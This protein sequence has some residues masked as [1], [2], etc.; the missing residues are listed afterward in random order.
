[1]GRWVQLAMVV[2]AVLDRTAVARA[3]VAADASPSIAALPVEPASDDAPVA[4]PEPV[5]APVF[6]TQVVGRRALPKSSPVRISDDDIRLR[7]ASTVPEALEGLPGVEI[8]TG[9]KAGDSLQIRGLDERGVLLLLDGIPIRES[10]AGHF[11]IGSLLATQ[12]GSVEV[13]RGISSVLYGANSMAGVVSLHSFEDLDGRQGNLTLTLGNP[14]RGRLRD[15][16]GQLNLVGGHGAWSFG[17]S[18]ARSQSDGFVVSN[19]FT[20]TSD[21]EAFHENGGLRDGSDVD[22]TML[23][24][25]ASYEPD[26]QWRVESIAHVFRQERGIPTFESS[27]Y[28]RHWRFTDYNTYL[29][30]L[31]VEYQPEPSARTWSL[32]SAKGAGYV[33][34]HDDTLQDYQDASYRQLTTHPLA[35]FVASSY[36]DQSAGMVLTPSWN[37]WTGNRIDLSMSAAYDQNRQR[38]IPV[39]TTAVNTEWQP[40]ETYG[41]ATFNLAAEDTQRLGRWR[42]S[43]GV[44]GSGMRL[45]AEE[46]RAH[47]YPVHERLAL[48]ADGRIFADYQWNEQTTWLIAAGR[49]TR[50]PTLK[51]LFSNSLGGNS[52]LQPE[53]AWMAEAGFD[54]RVPTYAA[55]LSARLYYNAVRALIEQ[56][57]SVYTNVSRATTAG[58]ELAASARPFSFVRLVGQYTY[59]YA[60]D[61]SADRPLD[62]RTPHHASLELRIEAPWGSEAAVQGQYHSGQRAA[63][64][65]NVSNAWQHERLPG[66]VLLHIYVQHRLDLGA[67]RALALFVRLRNALD[68][69]Y[70][71][72]SFTPEPGRQV[73]V[74][75]SADF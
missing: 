23:M 45:T 54:W 25:K 42:L 64:F 40:W 17:G 33:T 72:G 61:E 30:G 34:W 50:Y 32:A 57:Y 2:C 75:M 4:E 20:T 73:F 58:G 12:L 47:S 15:R 21:T 44:G 26:A 66:Y 38:E 3:E 14:Y 28:V 7:G 71:R 46:I 37:L 43:V 53:H 60:H 19:D 29:G 59:L 52:D 56:R 22:K 48:A 16:S 9:T 24:L 1:M 55:L 74:G 41:A 63:F 49:K 70:V 36:R 39:E 13:Q 69:N 8:N 27:G 6:E 10:Y 35:W 62:Y 68:S 11:D 18:A 5:A 67:E 65:N 31:I 51:E